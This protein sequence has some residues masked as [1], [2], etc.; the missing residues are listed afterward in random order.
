MPIWT[1][2]L[3]LQSLQGLVAFLKK[4]ELELARG[5]Q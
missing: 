1:E 5:M 2:M 4:F 3:L